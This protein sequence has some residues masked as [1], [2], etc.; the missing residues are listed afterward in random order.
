MTETEVTSPPVVVVE[1][2]TVI[3][4]VEGVAPA[5]VAVIVALPADTAVARPTELTVA[6]AGALELQVTM[7]VT[8][9]VVA[10]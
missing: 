4:P 7:V 8:S 1:G 2:V 6:T 9:S 5:M 10:G 3:V